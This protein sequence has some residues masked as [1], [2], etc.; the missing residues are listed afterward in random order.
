MKKRLEKSKC[1]L[2]QE[3]KET[4]RQEL[5]RLRKGRVVWNPMIQG[6]YTKDSNH[7]ERGSLKFGQ[8]AEKE[9]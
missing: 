2:N 4:G 8:K 7:H 9:K 3:R 6:T 1:Q 5:K